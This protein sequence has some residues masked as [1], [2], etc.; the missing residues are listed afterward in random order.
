MN[1]VATWLNKWWTKIAPK[2]CSYNIY[3]GKT[4]IYDR[5]ETS[6]KKK[7][8]QTRMFYTWLDA[9][10]LVLSEIKCIKA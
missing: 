6:H 9:Q 10:S 5:G 1:G 4:T 3:R 2:K 7:I 8:H